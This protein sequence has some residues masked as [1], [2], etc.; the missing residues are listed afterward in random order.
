M[1]N[2]LEHEDIAVGEFDA[3]AIQLPELAFDDAQLHE[4]DVTGVTSHRHVG[5]SVVTQL[6][7]CDA[8]QNATRRHRWMQENEPQH[9]PMVYKGP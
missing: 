8:H 4:G 9:N 1:N 3:G 2:N 5:H 7:G 6:D